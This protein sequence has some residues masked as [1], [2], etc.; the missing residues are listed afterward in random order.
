MSLDNIIN[1]LKLIEKDSELNEKI[2]IV[3]VFSKKICI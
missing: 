3:D 1:T 2:R